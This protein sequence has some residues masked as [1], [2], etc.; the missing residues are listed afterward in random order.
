M[1]TEDDPAGPGNGIEAED[2]GD[3]VTY[4]RNGHSEQAN[5]KQEFGAEFAF[6]QRF[7]RNHWLRRPVIRVVSHRFFDRFIILVIIANSVI[8]ALSDFSV[9][10]K[11]L[12]P[13][14]SGWAFRNGTVVPATSFANY[15][16]SQSEIPFTCIYAAE[17]ILKIMAM[18]ATGGKGSY[19]QDQWNILDFVVVISR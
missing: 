17:A 14:S 13:A 15:I 3:R 1:Q 11:Q 7:P 16:V 8:L 5:K 12:N 9:V 10:D 4:R 19:F 6:F 2:A 18:G